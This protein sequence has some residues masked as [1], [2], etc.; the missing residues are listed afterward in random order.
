MSGLEIFGVAASVIQVADFGAKLSVQLFAFYRQVKTANEN[1]Q[2]LSNEVA[3]VSAILRELGESLKEEPSAK[4]CSDEAFQTLKRVLDESRDVLKQIERAVNANDQSG[5]SRIQQVAGKVRLA[6]I[7]PSLNPLKSNLE[8]LKATMLLLLNVIM[9]AAKVRNR[10][11]P[12]LR[13]Q[14]ALIEALLQE[15][16]FEKDGNSSPP[17]YD[18]IQHMS[19]PELPGDSSPAN[20][21]QESEFAEV[22]EYNNLIHKMLHE[23]DR[24]KSKLERS[25]SSRIRNGV[26][27]IHHSEVIRFQLTHGH[28]ILQNFDKSLLVD[29]NDASQVPTARIAPPTILHE[30][31]HVPMTKEH[32]PD[33]AGQAMTR[34][35]KVQDENYPDGGTGHRPTEAVETY[36]ATMS[37]DWLGDGS[38]VPLADFDFDTF[39]EV[40]LPNQRPN[41]VATYCPEPQAHAPAFPLDHLAVYLQPQV[42]YL[43]PQVVYLQPQVV[44]LQPQVVY[45]Q[46]QVVHPQPQVVHPQPQVVHPQPQVVYLQPQVVYLQ[47]Q[48]VYLQ[49]QVV[50]LHPQVVYLHHQPI[51]PHRQY[52]L[53]HHRPILQDHRPILQDHRPIL[54]DHRADTYSP[55]AQP[56]KAG[57]PTRSSDR[58]PFKRKGLYS[59]TTHETYVPVTE[60][61][62]C[63]DEV[64]KHSHPAGLTTESSMA[65]PESF[66]DLLMRWTKLGRSEVQAL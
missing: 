15:K 54:Q 47:P 26:L 59:E 34:K 46:P 23:I 44:Y 63:Q 21:W 56:E 1:I 11:S 7:E 4:L 20:P 66:E 10:N 14:R 5:K 33:S 58:K 37:L 24:C 12:S 28:S 22:N 62:Y 48:V 51:R 9:F 13:D 3:L 60:K 41:S 36:E 25:R 40:E 35:H 52:L 42:V 18:Q 30:V 6:L 27:S 17:K 16:R 61:N 57:P 38:D 43:Q 32:L 45:L 50:Y 55:E 8:R 53:L 39:T 31:V 49:P 19:Q 2:L 65:L 64:E 29:E